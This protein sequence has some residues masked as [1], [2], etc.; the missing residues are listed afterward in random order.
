MRAKLRRLQIDKGVTT[1][2]VTH[3]QVEA[4]AMSDRI[5]IMNLGKLQQVGTPD[6]VYSYPANLFVANFIGSPSMNFINC[7]FVK[8]MRS[9]AIPTNGEVLNYKLPPNIRQNIDLISDGTELVLG[10]R[11]EDVKLSPNEV[12]LGF[13]GGLIFTESLGS[14]NIHHISRHN[15]GLKVRTSPAEIYNEGQP[16]WVTFAPEGIRIFDKKTELAI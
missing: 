5:A 9:V 13:E 7:S 2:Y 12:D 15:L 10:I 4:M 3:D 1:I 8:E 16:I 11:P 14:E 6:E